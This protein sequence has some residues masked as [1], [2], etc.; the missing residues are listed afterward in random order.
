MSKK[1]RRS[2]AVSCSAPRKWVSSGMPIPAGSSART[3]RCWPWRRWRAVRAA[4]V[5]AAGPAVIRRRVRIV[6][7]GG[8][9]PAEDDQAGEIL[10]QADHA[11]LPLYNV[12]LLFRRESQG[13]A[14]G[15][16]IPRLAGGTVGRSTLSPA[17]DDQRGPHPRE[18]PVVNCIH[19]AAPLV[20]EQ[21]P[22]RHG[23]PEGD[24]QEINQRIGRGEVGLQAMVESMQSL[25]PFR[26]GLAQGLLGNL[27]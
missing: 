18:Q 24:T 12:R 11:E 16:M 6:L 19:E 17:L 4:P 3:P 9:M 20:W 25:H 15:G 8:A 26:P 13:S 14:P 2:A 5:S 10:C 21:G 1:V 27:F 7:R 23:D 22:P